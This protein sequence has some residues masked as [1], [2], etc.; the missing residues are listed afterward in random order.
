MT[1]TTTAAPQEDQ[2]VYCAGCGKSVAIRNITDSV[3][4][5]MFCRFCF[6]TD[7][8]P[9]DFEDYDDFEGYE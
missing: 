3:D 4:G 2:Y 5:Y 7:F 6:D 9:D 8:D 1:A